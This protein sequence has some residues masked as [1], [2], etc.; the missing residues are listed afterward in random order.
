MR[1]KP[2]KT[3][4]KKDKKT[5][6]HFPKLLSKILCL[7]ITKTQNWVVQHQTMY[8]KYDQFHHWIYPQYFGTLHSST[9]GHLAD[10]ILA[11]LNHSLIHHFETVPNSKKLQK[12]TEL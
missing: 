12:T 2:M 8:S 6:C 3:L 9:I 7:G 5:M 1:K 10:K 4:W 11:S